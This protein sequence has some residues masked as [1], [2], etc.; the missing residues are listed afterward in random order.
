MPD[1]PPDFRPVLETLIANNV[2]FVVI[3]GLA[4]AA[5]GSAYVTFDI[6]VGYA[7]DR[8]NITAM[9]VALSG[10]NPRLRG[11]P[12]GLPFV[13]DDQTLRGAAN[14]TLETSVSPVDIL[15]NIPGIDSFEGLWE[16]S[17]IRPLYGLAVHVASI[18]DLISMKR[19]ANRPKDQ[20]HILELLALKKLL[21]AENNERNL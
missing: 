12:E 19:A 20:N 14:M 16:R 3:G 9:R 10:L 13:W 4:M 21:A 15:S 6:D 18:E 2:R 5:L 17:V 1:N 11:F 7:R 8:Q